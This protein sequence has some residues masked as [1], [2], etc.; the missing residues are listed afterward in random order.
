[1]SQEVRGHQLSWVPFGDSNPSFCLVAQS[2]PTLWDPMDWSP[3]GFSVHGT[4]Q[5]RILE[6]GA[7]SFS[8]GSSRL[9]DQTRVS[10]IGRQI[11]YP[12]AT[13]EVPN[14]C[15]HLQI[16]KALKLAWE[17]TECQRGQRHPQ[18]ILVFISVS[19]PAPL[20][21]PPSG[22]FVFPTQFPFLQAS[23][24]TLHSF[25]QY[26]SLEH[27]LCASSQLGRR[28]K[29]E[30]NGPAALQNS[31]PARLL[32]PVI[33]ETQ[34][35]CRSQ[36]EAPTQLRPQHWLRNRA[37]Q[38]RDCSPPPIPSHSVAGV[39]RGTSAKPEGH[40]CAHKS[41]RKHGCSKKRQQ[42]LPQPVIN[43]V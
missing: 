39:M 32:S 35:L 30:Y 18:D 12:R 17:P 10:F 13:W 4:L 2:C 26:S 28:D 21:T 37:T 31:L 40:A 22:G 3:P 20:Q 24:L 42:V 1:M 19:G 8:R 38:G 43:T 25:T 16:G 29:E 6:W 7:I 23:R 5:A 14:P 41:G 9:R 36:G 27:R 15:S 11:L 33:C 34:K